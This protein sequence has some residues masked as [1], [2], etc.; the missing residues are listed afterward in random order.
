MWCVP[1]A[2]PNPLPGTTHYTDQVNY[3]RSQ[4]PYHSGCL[5]QLQGIKFIGQLSLGFG[6]CNQVGWKLEPRKEIHGAIGWLT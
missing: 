4:S 6:G 5:Q 3:H 1:V 2:C